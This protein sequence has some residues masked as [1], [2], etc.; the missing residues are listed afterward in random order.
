MTPGMPSYRSS[1]AHLAILQA[2]AIIT[3]ASS[4]AST[5]SQRLEIPFSYAWRFHYGTVGFSPSP[6]NPPLPLPSEAP[7]HSAADALTISKPNVPPSNHER[8]VEP[9]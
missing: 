2:L 5:H 7:A 9:P 1:A 8:G 3:N 6:P 4:S